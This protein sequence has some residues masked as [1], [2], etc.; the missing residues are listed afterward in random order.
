MSSAAATTN[1]ARNICLVRIRMASLLDA[2]DYGTFPV[3]RW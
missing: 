3:D 1:N 2:P